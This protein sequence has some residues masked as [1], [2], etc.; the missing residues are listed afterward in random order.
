MHWRE[1]GLLHR[2]IKRDDPEQRKDDIQEMVKQDDEPDGFDWLVG[3][4][5]WHAYCRRNYS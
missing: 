4:T 1:L 3:V 2:E 5:N